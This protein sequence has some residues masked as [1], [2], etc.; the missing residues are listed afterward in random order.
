MSEYPIG[1]QRFTAS[2]V[3]GRERQPKR[4]FFV[5]MASEASTAGVIHFKSADA[6]GDI[7]ATVIGEAGSGNAVD[8]GS[9]YMPQGCFIQLGSTSGTSF[10]VVQYHEEK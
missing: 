3:L 4:V 2:G 7:Y 6:S 8:L 1:T 5:T 10:A 9:M